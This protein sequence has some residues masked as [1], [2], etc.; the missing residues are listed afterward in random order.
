MRKVMLIIVAVILSMSLLL[1][2]IGCKSEAAEEAAEEVTEEAEETVEEGEEEEVEEAEET[3]GP[4]YGGVL[5]I[6]TTAEGAQPLG[7][8][9]ENTTNDTTLVNT[10]IETLLR[11]DSFGN[12]HPF[13]AKDYDVDMDAKTVTLNLQEN[14]KFHDGTPFNAEAAVWSLN[15]AI[16]PGVLPQYTNARVVDEF[17]IALDFESFANSALNALAGRSSGFISPTAFEENGIEWARKNPVGTGPFKFESFTRGDILVLVRNDD[18]WQEGKPY[19]DGVSYHFI[20]DT[21]TQQAALQTEGEQGIDVLTTNSG[22]VI[23][24]MQAAGLKVK[25]LPIGPV[26]L[27]PS[28]THEDSP[29]SKLEVRQAIY[30]AIDRDSIVE[31]RGFGSWT[32]AYQYAPEGWSAH[33]DSINTNPYNPDKAKE[34]LDKAG[35]ADGFETKIIGMPN[36][37]D[38]DAMV[39]IQSMLAQVG[40]TV[41]LEFPD[42][43]GYLNQR[44]SDWNGMLGQHMRTLSNINTTYR[45]YIDPTIGDLPAMYRSQELI[46][47]VRESVF[48]AELDDELTRQINQMMFDEMTVIPLYNIFDAF[49]MKANVNDT[50]FADFG[51]STIWIPEDAWISSE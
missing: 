50:G 37:A 28:S 14:V 12:V 2:G 20:A 27:V 32:P 48:T 3:G 34:L 16:E 7:V 29:L 33:M 10:F 13:L 45:I 17:T 23:A 31:A 19:L 24:A 44:K 1:L 40:I 8:P 9:W 43:G 30:Y 51:S 35:Y 46:D 47:L 26:V 15:R 6:V 25:F 42:S 36:F 22:E 5:D 4:E 18:Y 38:K 39:A 21:M 41:E 11:E 49:V